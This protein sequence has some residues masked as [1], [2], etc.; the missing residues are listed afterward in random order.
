ML[1]NYSRQYNNACQDGFHVD[2]FYDRRRT[3]ACVFGFHRDWMNACFSYVS[4]WDSCQALLI[5]SARSLDLTACRS[6]LAR[7]TA[8][9]NPLRVEKLFG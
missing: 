8:K 2:S 5:V 9:R 4:S 1:G 7:I 6:V 3:F